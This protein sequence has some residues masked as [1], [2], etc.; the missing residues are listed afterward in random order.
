MA[1]FL[2]SDN[3]FIDSDGNVVPFK[4]IVLVLSDCVTLTTKVNGNNDYIRMTTAEAS[5]I[6]VRFVKWLDKTKN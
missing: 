2:V 3:Y 6:K 1:K 5:I 4:S